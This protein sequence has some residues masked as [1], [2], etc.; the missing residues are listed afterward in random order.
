VDDVLAGALVGLA[1]A[2]LAWRHH[3]AHGRHRPALPDHLGDG[4]A[5]LPLVLVAREDG[6]GVGADAVAAAALAGKNGGVGFVGGATATQVSL[7]SHADPAA[8]ALSPA[9]GGALTMQRTH[10]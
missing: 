2:L 3:V 10:P 9:G 7:V 1:C 4:R 6:A 5:L 8:A